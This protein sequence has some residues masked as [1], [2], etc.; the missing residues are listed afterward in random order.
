M[1]VCNVLSMVMYREAL[2][3]I[4]EGVHKAVWK[5]CALFGKLLWRSRCMPDGFPIMYT[6]GSIVLDAFAA[7]GN[8]ND[9]LCKGLVSDTKVVFQLWGLECGMQR[10]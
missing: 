10:V 5:V 2:H 6:H 3:H 8:V 9:K 7:F 4:P 1:L